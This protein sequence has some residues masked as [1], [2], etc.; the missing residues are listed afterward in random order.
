MWLSFGAI[1]QNFLGPNRTGGDDRNLPAYEL[2]HDLPVGVENEISY[3]P[4]RSRDTGKLDLSGKP[5]HE[6]PITY[7]AAVL[8][9]AA[10]CS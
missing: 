1:V 4:V 7:D 9:L 8:D 5:T 2:T 10:I 6:L 3:L